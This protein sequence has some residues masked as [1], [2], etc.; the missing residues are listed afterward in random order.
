M[1]TSRRRT[2]L[3]PNDDGYRVLEL[4]VKSGASIFTNSYFKDDFIF[5]LT[6]FTNEKPAHLLQVSSTK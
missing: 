3:K 1:I 6:H 4:Q 2:R 5:T